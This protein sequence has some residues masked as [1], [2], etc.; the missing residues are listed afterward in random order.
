MIHELTG[1]PNGV[2]GFEGEGEL[3]ADDCKN[4]LIPAIERLI[5]E[6]GEVRAVLVFPEFGGL[7]AGGTWQDLK[8]GVTFPLAERQAAIDWA[9]S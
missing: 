9:A 3:H 6:K 7:S 1:L 5:A 2:V 8:M 4:S